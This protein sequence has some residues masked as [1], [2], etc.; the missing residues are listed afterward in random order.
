MSAIIVGF[1]L[2]LGCFLYITTPLELYPKHCS[3][4]KI[5][6]QYTLKCMTEDFF[7]INNINIVSAVLG[8]SQTRSQVDFADGKSFYI[9]QPSFPIRI[10]LSE[11]PH[12]INTQSSL[13]RKGSHGTLEFS[14]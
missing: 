4:I 9:N 13:S 8:F 3:Q 7:I 5:F 10:G 1:A 6:G 11:I 12:R 2:L 14:A